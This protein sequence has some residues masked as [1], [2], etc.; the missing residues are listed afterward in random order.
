VFR[1]ET[2]ESR[3][4]M[5]ADSSRLEWLGRQVDTRA[6]SWVV[7]T[8]DRPGPVA[9]VPAVAGDWRLA[10][11]GE[12]FFSLV[13]P[14]AAAADVLGW[15]SRSPGVA[16][17][18]PD[19]VITS[20]ALPN[21]PSF[22]QLW[23]LN[24]VGQSGGV[25]DAD[26]DAPEAW[27]VTT[28]SRS[29]VVAVI[30]TGIDHNHPDLA[31]NIWRNPGEIP[32]DRIDNDGNGYVDD[33]RGWDFANRDAD[34]FDDE[35]HG[36][37]VAG[38]I[39]A[40]GNNGVGVAG[41]SWQVSMMP[42]KFLDADGSGSTSSAI[43][44]INYATRMRRD[45]GVNVVA[46]NNSW[47]GG[48]FSTALR[49]AIDAGGRAGILCVAAAGND[50]SNNDTTAHYPSSYAGSS[51]IA[52]AATDR[53]NRLAS[54][55]NYGATSV[56]IAAPGAAI[57]S[58]LP[59]N[60]YATYSG[61]SMA[62]PHV[63]GAIALLAAARPNATAAEIRAA[64]LETATP[65][66]ALAGKVA[67]G[68]LLNVAAA[69]QALGGTSSP[70]AGEPLTADVVDVTP[71]P[72]TTAVD[73]IT[74]VFNRAVL[75]FDVADLTLTRNG[76]A[77]SLAGATVSS[78]DGLRWTVGGLA[79]ATTSAGSYAFSVVATGSGIVDTSGTALATNAAD[80]WTTSAPTTA[81]IGDTLA[82]AVVV[83]TMSG[84]IRLSGTVG[85]GSFGTRDVDLFRVTLAAGQRLVIDV[86]AKTLS[87]SSTLDSYLR[88]FDAAGN[89]L[90]RNDD[91]GS[92]YDSRIALTAVVAGTYYVGVSGYGTPRY[93]PTLAGS[94]RS[95][96]TGVYQLSLAF[97][98]IT[99]A[100]G[101]RMRTLGFRDEAVRAG[102]VAAAFAGYEETLLEALPAAGTQRAA[103]IRRA[104]GC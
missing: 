28:G 74:V 81:D 88:F 89:Q 98:G 38:T 60:S 56:D 51:V 1:H 76:S 14:G 16:Y 50:G 26:I 35:G 41:V 84:S 47:G 72:R 46:T 83:P 85:D 45:F 2:L 34:P 40:V 87:G 80:A 71:D 4:L 32:G 63:S 25:S 86:D 104:T 43:A 7:R 10:A 19:F 37:H 53:S 8:V 90:A 75:G 94:G 13:A 79:A 58:T 93:S 95:G 55:S 103:R 100:G 36:T 91:D 73:A 59:G 65:L 24:N 62:T 5:A 102:G 69:M 61:T 57:Y 6:D 67:S 33:V 44:A 11:L 30:D 54:F 77:I 42:L 3:R 101:S 70:P 66:A 64:L 49:D 96:S 18:E 82:T 21:D 99:A 31:A 39:G 27:D 29:V 12:G 17:V 48:G 9:A 92:T 15:A 22:G 78:T 68:G 20:A 23:G 52:V 97:G